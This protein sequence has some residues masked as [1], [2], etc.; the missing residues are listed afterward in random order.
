VS[1]EMETRLRA[2]GWKPVF[3]EAWGLVRWQDPQTGQRYNLT[4]AYAYIQARREAAKL[5]QQPAAETEAGRG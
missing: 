3:D 2:V 1:D 5:R 4:T